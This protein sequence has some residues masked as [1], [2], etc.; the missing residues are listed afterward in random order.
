MEE[1]AMGKYNKI[2]IAKRLTYFALSA[3]IVLTNIPYAGAA[4][5]DSSF[6]CKI[7]QVINKVTDTV[8]KHPQGFLVLLGS[9]TVVGLTGTI[10]GAVRSSRA[11]KANAKLLK[12][13]ESL[14]NENNKLT[15]DLTKLNNKFEKYKNKNSDDQ[16]RDLEAE[17][18]SLTRKLDICENKK[19]NLERDNS[20]KLTQYLNELKNVYNSYDSYMF[21]K[22]KS[23]LLHLTDGISTNLK[24]EQVRLHVCSLRLKY[25]NGAITKEDLL[26]DI[27]NTL[28]RGNKLADGVCRL[29]K[30]ECL[31]VA[32]FVLGNQNPANTIDG[33]QLDKR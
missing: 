17:I 10:V 30:S 21:T 11:S 15:N 3:G 20:E 26:E 14:R 4:E 8:R 12:D 1:K 25:M 28:Y 13:N 27:A 22:G 7:D 2:N 31:R 5:K 29:D 18:S 23:Y 6:K 32:N 33:F 19:A 16:T 9:V 24:D